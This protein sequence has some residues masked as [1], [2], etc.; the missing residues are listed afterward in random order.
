MLLCV[1]C[2]TVQAISNF[3]VPTIPTS[4]K[5][6]ANQGSTTQVTAVSTKLTT[7]VTTNEGSTEFVSLFFYTLTN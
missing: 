5:A 6:T 4:T 3:L 2:E 7:N 1:F